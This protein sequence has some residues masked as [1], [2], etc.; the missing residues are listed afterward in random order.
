[1]IVVVLV[2]SVGLWYIFTHGPEIAEANVHYRMTQVA[3]CA[4]TE[5]LTREECVV[6]IGGQQ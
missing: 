3:T 6:L 2:A 1:M 5:Q 4:E